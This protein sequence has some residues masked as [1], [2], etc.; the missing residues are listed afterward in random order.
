MGR[1]F[2]GIEKYEWTRKV[3]SQLVLMSQFEKGS[4]MFLYSKRNSSP[5]LFVT[6]YPFAPDGL[7]RLRK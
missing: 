2:L 4:S 3:V 5:D 7:S 1:S 6:L